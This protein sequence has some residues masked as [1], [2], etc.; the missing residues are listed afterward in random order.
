MTI[1]SRL[2][3][4][5]FQ[6]DRQRHIKLNSEVCEHCDRKWCLTVCP[7]ECFLL[8][9]NKVEFSYEGCLECGTCKNVCEKGAINWVYPRGGFGTC[10]RHG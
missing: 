3:L 5:L 9:D 6:V 4:V 2:S 10:F 8:V 7:A 1:E